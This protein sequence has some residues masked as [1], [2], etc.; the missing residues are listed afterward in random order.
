MDLGLDVTTPFV[1]IGDSP[2]T[3]LLWLA[4]WIFLVV[5]KVLFAG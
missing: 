3:G 1:T 4:P 5:T 2:V